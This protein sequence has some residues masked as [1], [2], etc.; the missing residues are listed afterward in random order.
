MNV[1]I[2]DLCGFKNVNKQQKKV[3]KKSEKKNLKENP[4]VLKTVEPFVSLIVDLIYITELLDRV[5]GP[6]SKIMATI[7]CLQLKPT[8]TLIQVHISSVKKDETL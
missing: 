7:H 6:P 5:A 2:R 3:K 1:M 4:L 8:Q